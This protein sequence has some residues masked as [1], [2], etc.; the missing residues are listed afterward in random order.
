MLAAGVK[1]EAFEA[2]E[3]QKPKKVVYGRRKKNNNQKGP[4]KDDSPTVETPKPVLEEE[5]VK[6][7]VETK[8]EIMAKAEAEAAR[9]LEIVQGTKES[10]EEASGDDDV[11][12]AWDAD[13][14]ESDT[15]EAWDDET[16]EE[17]E[18]PKP[19]VKPAPA[20]VTKK[21]PEP[22]PAEESNEEEEESSEEDS[23]EDDDSEEESSD[24]DD[25]TEHQKQVLKRKEE[26]A[27]R[28]RVTLG[29]F[30]TLIS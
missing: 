27:G 24:E 8:D 6:E 21:E 23:E 20:K 11:K 19:V 22:Q 10:W 30:Q 7:V 26:A 28:K 15:K 17:K 3:D 25:L 9:M 16:D 18:A 2:K 13:S 29:I 14:N 12:D 5:N 4:Q 1:V